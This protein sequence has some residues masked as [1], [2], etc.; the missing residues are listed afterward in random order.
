MS[1]WLGVATAFQPEVSPNSQQYN[2]E[3]PTL[4]LIVSLRH[5]R[6]ENPSEHLRTL[7]YYLSYRRIAKDINFQ[8]QMRGN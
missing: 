2:K 5:F 4:P 1:A 3:F 6:K 7:L 8:E